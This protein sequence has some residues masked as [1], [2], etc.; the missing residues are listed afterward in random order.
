MAA[1]IASLQD[2][3]GCWH[4]SLLD[5]DSYPNPEMSATSF[6]VYGLAWGINNHYLDAVT[7]LPVVKRGW[8]YMTTA[9]SDKGMV[10]WIQ[11]IGY[12]PRHVTSEMTEVYGVG[13]FLLAGS[14]IFRMISE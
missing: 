12:D 6:F 10:G 3:N 8:Q 2:P 9:V 13:A 14:E 5:P 11:P 4:A 7:Y 1:K